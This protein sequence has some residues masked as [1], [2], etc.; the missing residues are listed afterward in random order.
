MCDFTDLGQIS[1]RL[2][3]SFVELIAVKK[4]QRHRGRIRSLKRDWLVVGRIGKPKGEEEC[5]TQREEVVR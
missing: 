3:S 1:P 4:R 2:S 5:G